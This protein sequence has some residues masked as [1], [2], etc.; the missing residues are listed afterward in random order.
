MSVH[1]SFLI[2]R[3]SVQA[4]SAIRRRR[5]PFPLSKTPSRRSQRFIS[6]LILSQ[7]FPQFP[8]IVSARPDFI[9]SVQIVE[10]RMKKSGRQSFSRSTKVQFALTWTPMM[11]IIPHQSSSS[12]HRRTR[13]RSGKSSRYFL[14]PTTSWSMP[15]VRINAA[16]QIG[17]GLPWSGAVDIAVEVVTRKRL[18]VMKIVGEIISMMVMRVMMTRGMS[19][20][21]RRRRIGWKHRKKSPVALSAA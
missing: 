17:H 1:R 15:A 5:R 14:Y 19:V 4:P 16:H 10:A 13:S 21:H 2:S 12:S 11:I 9:S 8:Q 20:R 18:M 6:S 7:H 3:E